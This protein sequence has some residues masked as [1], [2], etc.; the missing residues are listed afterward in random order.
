[1]NEDYEKLKNIDLIVNM[2][3]IRLSANG[4]T[5]TQIR[6]RT[7]M[8]ERFIEKVLEEHVDFCGF[9]YPVCSASPWWF[10]KKAN[11]NTV[12]DP[13]LWFKK[14]FEQYIFTDSPYKVEDVWEIMKKFE[15]AE[16]NHARLT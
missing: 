6:K 11:G 15:K 8:S 1:M 16:T 4:F 2:D 14:N 5:N 7:G 3:I 12:T 10:Y 9:A 13:K